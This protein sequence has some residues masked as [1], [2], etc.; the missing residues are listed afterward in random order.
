MAAELRI[1]KRWIDEDHG[2]S[3]RARLIV[4]RKEDEEGMSD[5]LATWRVRLHGSGDPKTFKGLVA[6]LTETRTEGNAPSGP[7]K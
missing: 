5:F 3:T 1:I 7:K 2:K 6:W 4:L